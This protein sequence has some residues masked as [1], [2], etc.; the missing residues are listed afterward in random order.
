MLV[1]CPLQPFPTSAWDYSRCS[2]NTMCHLRHT[3]P[4]GAN[5]L[6]P[7]SLDYITYTW[8]KDEV[9]RGGRSASM[10]KAAGRG[11]TEPSPPPRAEAERDNTEVRANSL[12]VDEVLCGRHHDATGVHDF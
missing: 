12:Y 5:C 11:A 8:V 1:Y 9:P 3:S 4:S 10:H 7:A 6:S 2:K